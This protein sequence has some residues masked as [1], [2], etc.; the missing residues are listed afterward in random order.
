MDLFSCAAKL[1]I[2]ATVSLMVRS[3]VAAISWCGRLYIVIVSCWSVY[4]VI[5]TRAWNIVTPSAALRC[6]SHRVLRIVPSSS[7]VLSASERC[8]G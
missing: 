5:C 6:G 8:I 1:P 2:A 3:S 4:S 7:S